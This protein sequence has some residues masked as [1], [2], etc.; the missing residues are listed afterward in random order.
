[1]AGLYRAIVPDPT[2][3]ARVLVYLCR[4]AKAAAGEPDELRELTGKGRRQAQELG[5]RLAAANEPP[6]LVL[7]SPLVRARQ[8]AAAIAEATGAPVEVDRRLAPG[9]TLAALRE[10]VAA[11]DGPVATVG[12]QPDCSEI[13]LAA[14]GVDPGFSPG[15]MARLELDA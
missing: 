12:H 7:T 11:A 6:V 10:A 4:H 1:M 5:A 2:I 9:A 14:T 15:A 8:T 13:A 3:L